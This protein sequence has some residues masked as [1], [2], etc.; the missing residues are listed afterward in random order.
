[1]PVV[2]SL[3]NHFAGAVMRLFPLVSV[4]LLSGA[5]FLPCQ[6][7]QFT[8]LTF[9]DVYRISQHNGFGGI[10]EMATLLKRERHSAKHHLTCINGDFLS[11]SLMSTVTKGRHMVQLFNQLEV[12]L[13]VLGNH[14]FDF[15]TQNVRD[16]MACSEFGW[17][18]ANCL[19]ANGQYLTGPDQLRVIPCDGYKV[20]VFGLVTPDTAWLS[21]ADQGVRFRPILETAKE[22]IARLKDAGADVLIAMTHLSI[23]EDRQ[24]AHNCPDLHVILGGH[25]HFPL[26]WYE[27]NTLIHKSG[28]DAQFLC[29]IDL[30]LNHDRKGNL[31][32]NP[33]WQMIANRN[34]P[35]EIRVQRTVE[36]YQGELDQQLNLT[37]ADLREDLDSSCVRSSE[38]SFGDL[39]ADALCS[40]L[41]ADCA[42]LNAGAV[43]GGRVHRAGPLTK[44][45]LVGEMPFDNHVGLLRLSGKILRQA[46][47]YGLCH[48]G[49]GRG[50]FLQVSGLQVLFD[51]SRPPGNRLISVQCHGETLQDERIYRVACLDYLMAG[52]DGFH[53]LAAG[54]VE[55]RA[56]DGPLALSAVADYLNRGE[57]LQ[58]AFGTRLRL[59]G[60]ES[61]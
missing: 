11:P 32:V 33:T 60:S 39:V 46:L 9:N 20:G 40:A 47:E 3:Q 48:Y 61:P 44:A 14:E 24:L 17:L 52:G 50:S 45:A 28:Y 7:A 37:L 31:C 26:T 21:K 55:R 29:R 51:A 58:T 10:A 59:V 19:D 25:E 57:W 13:I 56:E 43:R 36:C 23:N 15:G 49:E 8:L 5:G 2:V 42:L 35:P 53:F 1:M 4:F 12:D 16:L 6:A 38:S 54:E 41:Q 18:A 27:G 30:D 34:I 22:M